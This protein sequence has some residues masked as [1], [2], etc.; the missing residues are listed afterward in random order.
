MNRRPPRPAAI[1]GELTTSDRRVKANGASPGPA[2]TR[3]SSSADSE[4]DTPAAPLATVRHGE[5][6]AR[7]GCL[8][9][10]HAYTGRVLNV[11]DLEPHRVRPLLRAEYDSLVETGAFDG[12]RVELLDGLLVTMTPQDAA[13]AYTVERLAHALTLALADRA[14]VRVQSPLALGDRSQPEPDIAVVKTAD[15]SAEHPAAALVVI[16]VATSSLRQD[17]RVKTPLYATANIPE[18]WLVDVKARRIDV[19]CDPRGDGYHTIAT[20]A[21]S[22]SSRYPRSP[23]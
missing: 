18:L 23:T 3:V 9:A 21:E 1:N 13:H 17:R 2:H 22:E 6:P 15:Y 12:E 11:A 5:G 4:I 10:S 19:H 8:V 16:E 7:S 14:I 20:H